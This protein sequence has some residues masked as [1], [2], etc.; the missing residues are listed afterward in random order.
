MQ[1]RKRVYDCGD[2]SELDLSPSGK[3]R[4]YDADLLV[5]KPKMRD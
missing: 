2:G 1:N 3:R 5:Y 4:K